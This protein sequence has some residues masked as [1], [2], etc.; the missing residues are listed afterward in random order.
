MT[1]LR[2]GRRWLPVGVA[3]TIASPSLGTAPS[4]AVAASTQPQ[5]VFR[6]GVDLVRVDALVTRDGAPVGGL[7]PAD[8]ELRDDGVVQTIVDA[9]LEQMPLEVQLVL[10]RS[11]SV[12]AVNARTL[13]E[14]ALVFLEGLTSRDRAGL[15]TF[16]ERVWQPQPLTPNLDLVGNRLAEIHGEGSTALHDAIYTALRLR[17]A[18]PTRGVLVVLTDGVDNVSWLARGEVI[19]AAKR[20]DVIV[21]TV[22]VRPPGARSPTPAGPFRTGTQSSMVDHPLFGGLARETGGRVWQAEWGPKL[23]EAFRAVLDDLRSRYM[24]TYYPTGVKEDGWHELD[25]RVKRGGQVTA[26]AGYFRASRRR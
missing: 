18:S 22:V 16:N 3:L 10:D 8:F 24:L 11:A 26:R 19:D 13:R 15:L 1:R 4:T 14:A 23:A 6:S 2:L 17:E 25:V 12:T 20:T 7:T 21:H 9:T 5:A